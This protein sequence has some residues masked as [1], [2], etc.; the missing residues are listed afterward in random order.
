MLMARLLGPVWI[1]LPAAGLAC[2]AGGCVAREE[3]TPLGYVIAPSIPADGG[4]ALA[5]GGA[6]G[7]RPE[8]GAA[9]S[10]PVIASDA[11]K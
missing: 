9:Y 3:T 7:A 8:G 6:S 5:E 2:S 1:A 11:R 10:S 4:P